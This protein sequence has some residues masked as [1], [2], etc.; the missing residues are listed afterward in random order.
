VKVSSLLVAVKRIIGGIQIQYDLFRLSTGLYKRFYKE[1]VDRFLTVAYLF[2]FQISICPDKK[3]F[4]PIQSAF[5]RKRLSSIPLM[6]PMLS[7]R[8][9]LPTHRGQKWIP[10]QLIMIVY[11][12]IAKTNTYRSLSYQ[13]LH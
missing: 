10:A 2:I 12:F 11:I 9:E 4:Q 1:P 8:I 6:A 13:V 3:R 7:G 5:T